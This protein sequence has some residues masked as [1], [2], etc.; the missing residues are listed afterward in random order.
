MQKEYLKIQHPFLIKKKKAKNTR[1]F[2]ELDKEEST[3]ISQINIMLNDKRLLFF[4]N[5]WNKTR[6]SLLDMVFSIVLKFLA[7]AFIEEK[8]EKSIQIS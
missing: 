5:I 8:W 4:P 2:P 1:K 3:K 6:M 7:M